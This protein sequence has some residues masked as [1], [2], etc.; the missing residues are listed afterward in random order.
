MTCID[1]TTGRRNMIPGTP[2]PGTSDVRPL[3]VESSTSSSSVVILRC[4]STR[5][6][7][8]L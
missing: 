8:V 7:Y 5:T 1:I 6:Y 3:V 4:R 2:V